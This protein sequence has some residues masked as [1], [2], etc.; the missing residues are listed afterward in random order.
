MS[1]TTIDIRDYIVDLAA[2]KAPGVNYEVVLENNTDFIARVPFGA[3][4]RNALS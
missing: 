4:W 2:E 3:G 1:T